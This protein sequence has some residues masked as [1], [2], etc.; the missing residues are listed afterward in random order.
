MVN[1][2]YA[3]VL[4]KK[5]KAE[6]ILA[7]PRSTKKARDKALK[8]VA[9]PLCHFMDLSQAVQRSSPQ[10][11]IPCLHSHPCVWSYQYDFVLPAEFHMKLQGWPN[12]YCMLAAPEDSTEAMSAKTKSLAGQ[13]MTLPVLAAVIYAYYLNPHAPWWQEK[14]IVFA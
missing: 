4:N 2:G 1:V 3:K 11:Q 13:G 5:R 10:R 14:G 6:E 7:K 9:D 12:K 8:D